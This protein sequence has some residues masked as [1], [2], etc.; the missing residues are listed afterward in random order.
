MK[1][2]DLLLIG[3]GLVIACLLSPWFF[4]LGPIPMTL[5]SLV[6]LM[7]AAVLGKKNGTIIT[8]LYLLAGAVGLPVLAGFQSGF[9][10]FAGR[11]AGFLWA[12][13]LVSFYLGWQ[14]ERGQ[15]TF[16][17]FIIYFFRAHILLLIAGAIVAYGNYGGELYQ[18][19]IRLLPGL[20]IKTIVGGLLSFYLIKKLPPRW[21]KAYSN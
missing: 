20:L 8:A 12:F 6:L 4:Y 11:T 13:P 3:I 1:T 16:I 7:L 2:K 15:K 21:T 17:H 10:H 9:E 19:I 5:Q 18:G 14:I